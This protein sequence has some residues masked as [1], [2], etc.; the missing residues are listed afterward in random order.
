MHTRGTSGG[1]NPDSPEAKYVLCNPSSSHGSCLVV[2]V[3]TLFVHLPYT[4]N[5]GECTRMCN[6]LAKDGNMDAL[7]VRAS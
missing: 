7:K 1:Q 6:F 5:L 2:G 3:L 4:E